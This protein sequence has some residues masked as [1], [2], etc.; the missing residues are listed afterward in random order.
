[1]KKEEIEKVMDLSYP[2]LKKKAKDLSLID[3]YDIASKTW[4]DLQNEPKENYDDQ[5]E[6]HLLDKIQ[7]DRLKHSK[8][9]RLNVGGD[10]K[11]ELM[12]MPYGFVLESGM[13]YDVM[14]DTEENKIID[15]FFNDE[16]PETDTISEKT[17]DVNEDNCDPRP[18][19][20][21]TDSDSQII[22]WIFEHIS[23][24][25]DVVGFD[26]KNVEKN[27]RVGN[28]VSVDLFGE[29]NE[30]K[31]IVFYGDRNKSTDETLQ[32]LMFKTI[33]SYSEK[34]IWIANDVQE[35]HS[36]IV[37]WLNDYHR[38]SIQFYLIEAKRIAN[39]NDETLITTFRLVE[40]PATGWR[41]WV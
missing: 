15:T 41:Y 9:L 39:S 30:G 29:D 16:C 2:Y 18:L 28:V 23:Q 12:Y 37:K 32:W 19:L 14:N 13:L 38:E 10:H 26:I 21:E 8:S 24:I 5:V 1:M 7:F 40:S 25:Q 31:G 34:A 6:Y 36:T 3:M 17:C 27:K 20:D 22:P 35:E 4:T 11:I 33:T